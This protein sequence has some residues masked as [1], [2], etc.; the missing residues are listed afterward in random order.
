MTEEI[1]QKMDERR[2]ATN[3]SKYTSI[4]REIRGMCRQ[5]KDQWLNQK[6]QEIEEMDMKQN[7]RGMHSQVKEMTNKNKK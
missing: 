3:T 1:L 4:D 7:I 6:C 5:T 2:Q